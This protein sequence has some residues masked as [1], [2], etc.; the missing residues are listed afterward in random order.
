MEF[1]N[2]VRAGANSIV[3]VERS[4]LANARSNAFLLL[5]PRDVD[6]Q[7]TMIEKIDL[8]AIEVR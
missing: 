5:N 8:V 1:Y 4:H 3:K 2:F 7:L 6:I